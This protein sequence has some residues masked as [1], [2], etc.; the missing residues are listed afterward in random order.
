MRTFVPL[1]TKVMCVNRGSRN[2]ALC[3]VVKPCLLSASIWNLAVSCS[4]ISSLNNRTMSG[5]S[6]SIAIRSSKPATAGK[7]IEI[8]TFSSA[9]SITVVSLT[10]SK[11]GQIDSMT[12]HSS[13]NNSRDLA[14]SGFVLL[15]SANTALTAQRFSNSRC[16]ISDALFRLHYSTLFCFGASV[17]LLEDSF[18]SVVFLAV[19]W[20]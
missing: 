12:C 3:K 7:T 18:S 9:E 20:N 5:L 19:R 15:G 1:L 17:S 4:C 6:S 14:T 16:N 11:M 2:V 10:G 8:L 13:L